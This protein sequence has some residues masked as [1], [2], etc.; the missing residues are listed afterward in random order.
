MLFKNINKPVYLIAVFVTILI[1]IHS[2]KVK[3]SHA[4]GLD[5]TYTCL[6]DNTYEFT[7]NFYQDCEGLVQVEY[8]NL[9]IVSANC[10]EFLSLELVEDAVLSGNEVSQICPGE[11]ST[12][13]GGSIQGVEQYIFNGTITLPE[14]CDDWII[15]FSECCRNTAI[16]NLD[17]PDLYDL[18]VE[19]LL[20]NTDGLCNNSPTFTSLPVPYL[21]INQQN[22]YNHGVFDVD[23]NTLVFS[24]INPM[25]A[26][27][28]DI[29]YNPGFDP[30]NPIT[31]DPG[32]FNFDVNSGQMIF[33][34]TMQEVDVVTVLV[35]EFDEYGNLIGS[36]IRDIQIILVDCDNQQSFLDGGITNIDINNAILIDTT[37][38]EVCPGSTLTFDIVGADPDS[39]D[40]LFMNTNLA[41]AIPD[42]IFTTSGINPVIG[43]F[44]WEPTVNDVG[45]NSFSVVLQDNSCPIPSSQ[46]FGFNIFVIEGANAGPD[47]AYC[48]SGGPATIVASGGTQ[49]TWT[50]NQSDLGILYQSPNGDTLQVAPPQATT[51][52][53]ETNLTANCLVLDTVEVTLAPDFPYTVSPSMDVCKFEQVQLLVDA[54]PSFGP[55]TYEWSPDNYLNT[56]EAANPVAAPL[57]TIDYTVVV[58]SAD[59]CVIT[60]EIS[61]N[62]S[63]VAPLVEVTSMENTICIGDSVQLEVITCCA[64]CELAEFTGEGN[65][66][67]PY[68]GFWEDGRVQILYTASELQDIG[69]NGCD[70]T[71][72]A[73][74]VTNKSSTDPFLGFT[75]K[76]GLTNLTEFGLVNFEPS[77]TTV[78]GPISYDT[79]PGWNVH[80]FDMPFNWD[81]VSNIIAEICFDNLDWSSADNISFTTTTFQSVL[82]AETDGQVGCDLAAE[83]A[84]FDRPDTR[85][86][87][88]GVSSL[89]SANVSWDPANSLDDSNSIT[90]IAMPTATT[91]YTISVD[92]NGCVGQDTITVFVTETNNIVAGPDTSICNDIPFQLF[93]DG[94]LNPSF[95]YDWSPATGLD[96]PNIATPMVSGLNGDAEYI[97]NIGNTGGCDVIDTVSITFGSSIDINL[98]ESDTICIGS[99]IPL[100]V[101]GGDIYDWQP[102]EGLSCNDCPSLLASPDST[103][104]YHL[105]ISDSQNQNC[106]AEADITIVVN[107]LPEVDAGE[108]IQ[109]Y[110]GEDVQLDVVG[111]FETFN[112]NTVEGLSDPTILDPYYT[113]LENTMYVIDV[114]NEFG[115]R[116]RDTL[117]LRFL[118]CRG[119]QVPT[120]FSPNSDGVND[121]LNVIN[122][123]QN[124]FIDFAIYSRWGQEMFFT[125]DINEGWDGRFKGQNQEVGTYVYYARVICNNENILKTGNITLIR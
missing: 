115:C 61:L 3:A 25:D 53:L 122:F 65:A 6:G 73:F 85:F 114:E 93:V 77:L 40:T 70:I 84:G 118:G 31:T 119:I 51:Y 120:A 58:T 15:S 66:P 9:S 107:P 29:D 117:N 43:S 24:L 56:F 47:L 71:S 116:N 89:L 82:Y 52:F 50:A 69:M 21:C 7:L 37:T 20:V 23:G 109:F 57:D 80:N 30:Q 36:I 64:E 105:T 99:Q 94:P 103:T 106:P 111:N 104:T 121:I 125:T 76:M 18:Y 62:V 81:G 2:Q 22:F 46:I 28:I 17:E 5:L 4:M 26:G 86:T 108:D 113:A 67:T 112:W 1:S 90:P 8:P 101:S 19:A 39:M 44:E 78:L 14:E 49:F 55:Y 87:T 68:E 95:T 123:G 10:G 11:S 124:E 27:A 102:N 48:P 32:D 74:N 60:E 45:L 38:I 91:L 12:C 88:N 72:I 96:N 100:S 41:N 59:G 54:D 13:D 98:A 79:T 92:N 35:E 16:T 63:G 34:P 75:I 110:L 42:A 83:T 33:T 97:V